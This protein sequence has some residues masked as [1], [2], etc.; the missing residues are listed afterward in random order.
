MRTKKT[1]VLSGQ[2]AKGESNPGT[3]STESL[4]HEGFLRDLQVVVLPVSLLRPRGSNP[5]THSRK[6]LR[7]IGK[8]IRKFGFTNPVLIDRDNC[9]IAGHGRI[10]A[11]KLVGL[12][13]VP[14]IC[15][16]DMT[17]AQKHAYAIADNRLAE[18]AGWD[19]RLIALELSYITELDINFDLTLTGFESGEIDLVLDNHDDADGDSHDCEDDGPSELTEPAPPVSRVGDLWLFPPRHRLLCGDAIKGDSFMRLMS[20]E[21]AQM[22]FTDPLYNVRISGHVSRSGS[23]KHRES[24]MASGEMSEIE[25][26]DFLRAV[27]DNLIQHSIDGSLHY[28]CTDWRHSFEMLSAGGRCTPNSRICAFGTKLRPVRVRYTGRSTS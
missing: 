21:Q 17:E 13:Q 11:A 5:R 16:D 8:S 28:M 3:K 18:N 19:Q 26:T 27:M 14:T 25:F 24:A 23:I 22:V 2:E 12:Q 20:G 6:Q 7:Q 10:E 1:V 15:L 4:L 9:V